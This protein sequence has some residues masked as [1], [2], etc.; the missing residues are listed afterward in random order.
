[1]YSKYRS[2]YLPD[3]SNLLYFP[4]LLLL[5]LVGFK[6]YRKAYR[7]FENLSFW[8]TKYTGFSLFAFWVLS[9]WTVKIFRFC[10]AKELLNVRSA[11]LICNSGSCKIHCI[12]SVLRTLYLGPIWGHSTDVCF[13]FSCY[14]FMELVLVCYALIEKCPEICL[15]A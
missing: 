4:L 15:N 14:F 3:F 2:T 6:A 7:K 13:F 10:K 11:I 9:I 8:R 1:M 5:C 12:C